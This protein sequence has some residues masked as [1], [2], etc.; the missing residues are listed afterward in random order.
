MVTFMNCSREET[1]VSELSKIGCISSMEELLSIKKSR[2][3]THD[4]STIIYSFPWDKVLPL[5]KEYEKIY[6]KIYDTTAMIFFKFIFGDAEG[7]MTLSSSE[8]KYIEMCSKS[9]TMELET[10]IASKTIKKAEASEQVNTS[11][12]NVGSSQLFMDYDEEE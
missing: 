10:G 6:S 3:I 5:M 9:A 11:S 12:A 2:S 4:R 7:Q 8:L 1:L